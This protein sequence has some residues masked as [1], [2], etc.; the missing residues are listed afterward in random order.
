MP[1]GGRHLGNGIEF[2]KPGHIGRSNQVCVPQFMPDFRS[3]VSLARHLDGIERSAC[4]SVTGDVQLYLQT[5]PVKTRDG[6]IQHLRREEHA[7]ELDCAV[8]KHVCLGEI[9]RGR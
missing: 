5:H 8:R 7:I 4:R 2:G 6:V 1:H 9:R 3:G